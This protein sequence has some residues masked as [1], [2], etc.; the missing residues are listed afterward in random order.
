MVAKDVV[1][2]V[3]QGASYCGCFL[4]G[5]FPVSFGVRNISVIGVGGVRT[6]M[7]RKVAKQACGTNS[8]SSP[9]IR[10]GVT[11]FKRGSAVNFEEVSGPCPSAGEP[12]AA[13]QAPSPAHAWRRRLAH[14][15]G[16]SWDL[17]T[18]SD[19][20]WFEVH[21]REGSQPSFSSKDGCRGLLP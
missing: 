10:L 14:A 20:W 1:L 21:V 8:C 6:Q 17:V 3:C 16:R 2:N 13:L 15:S 12:P 7:T 19:M 4:S 18:C 5:S 11:S 9:F